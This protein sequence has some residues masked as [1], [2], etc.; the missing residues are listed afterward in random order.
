M[1]LG[2]VTPTSPAYRLQLPSHSPHT[3]PSPPHTLPPTALPPIH[4]PAH[5]PGLIRTHPTEFQEKCEKVWEEDRACVIVSCTD[6]LHERQNL[7]SSASLLPSPLPRRSPRRIPRRI[8]RHIPFPV[9]LPV[10][11]PSP[12]HSPST[13]QH[14]HYLLRG[15]GAGARRAGAGAPDGPAV[16]QHL[17]PIPGAE[18]APAAD[19]AYGG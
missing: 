3:T 8:P 15:H 2:I 9:A 6:T 5:Y 11:F 1:Y 19:C 4:P 7:T 14:V 17:R 13:S 12:S 16:L 18:P 10:T